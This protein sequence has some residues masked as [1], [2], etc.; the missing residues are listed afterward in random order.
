MDHK[1]IDA[2]NIAERY[3]T[4]RLAPETAADFEE[5]YLDCP[6]CCGRVE[7]AERLERGLRR[8]AEDAAAG[9]PLPAPR[10]R[11]APSP[12]WGL[13]AAAM[14]VVAILP[15]VYGFREAER[16]RG[17]L[18]TTREALS[19]AEANR[20]EENRPETVDPDR[21][22]AIEN[23]LE[24]TR[25]ELAAEAEKRETLAREVAAG[26]QPQTHLPV[27]PLTP[28][29]SGGPDDGPV[30]SLTL[31]KEPG[32]IALWVEP[33]EDFPAYRATLRTG[34]GAVVFQASGLRLNDL[35][36]L[37]LTVHSTTLAPGSY[38]LDIEGL[39]ASGAPVQVSRFPLRIV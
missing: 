19:R 28:V 2:E 24:T 22:A 1:T 11:W 13:A 10:T 21:L 30:R 34:Q 8:L 16:L 9:A 29:R 35:G 18:A 33:G 38:R 36:A 23:E 4:G 6:A 32:W 26:R 27:L 5:H 37:L 39:P 17:D 31:P 14:L 3:V 12:R 25:R 15:G 20:P 7:A